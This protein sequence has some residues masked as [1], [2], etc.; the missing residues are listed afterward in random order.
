VALGRWQLGLVVRTDRARRRHQ[1]DEPQQVRLPTLRARI[2]MLP[3][4]PCSLVME[5]KMLV[6]INARAEWLARAP[7]A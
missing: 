5:R 1:T 3:M 7:A 6:G 2:A 4:E